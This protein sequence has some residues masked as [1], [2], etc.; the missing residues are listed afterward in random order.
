MTEVKGNRQVSL[1]AGTIAFFAGFAAVALYGITVHK[2]EPILHLNIVE[3]A[4]LV[5]I[6]LVTGAF[7]RI[8][9]SALV[10]TWGGRRIIFLQL[11]ISII[12]VLG[13][14]STLY[15][16]KSLSDLEAY[17]LLLLFGALAGTGISIFSS[18]ITYVSYWYPEKKQ[19][20]ALGIYAGLGNTAPGIFT[21]I[22][23][24][25]LLSLGLIGAY[26]GWLAFLV[27]MTIVFV[28]IGY[29][30]YYQQL[31]KRGYS[32]E[33][34]KSRALALGQEV[35]P[36][37][38]KATLKYAIRK[39]QTWLLV[40]MY[41]TSFG[42]FE[43]LTEWFPTYWTKYIGISLIEAGILTGIVY[44]LLAALIRVLG[45]FLSDKFGGERIS[46][47][48]YTILIVGSSIMILA[49]SLP[50]AITGEIV[51]AIGMGIANA[52]VYKLVPKY[53]PDAVGG[54]SGLV[55]GLGSAGGLILPPVLA[56]FVLILGKIG[57]SLGFSV[58]IALGLISLIFS[59]VLWN[60]YHKF[61]DKIKV[62][63]ATTQ[64]SNKKLT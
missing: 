36:T 41:F 58:Y 50:F 37:N 9:F 48:S 52:A 29:D 53:E 12:G 46:I 6:P 51:M 7:L 33:E 35:F 11:T 62:I 13:I 22:I 4:W 54:A 16:L 44:S 61:K 45:G 60:K 57:Y 10:D 1:V 32:Q 21:A 40:T 5:A 24:Y 49:H 2:I 20:T 64:S 23:P 30:N 28:L 31:L 26:E 18:G 42:G 15:K 25:A 19:G 27:A 47:M 39:W 8:P 63:E 56:Y 3:A 59:V 17:W 14:I 34:A 43:A 38:A 55:G